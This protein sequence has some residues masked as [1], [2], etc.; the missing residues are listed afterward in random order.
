MN[1]QFPQGYMNTKKLAKRCP[2]CK[3]YVGKGT[4][5]KMKHHL[6]ICES[7]PANQ[8]NKESEEK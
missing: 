8:V 6:P 3:K 5:T 7:N 1:L 4:G 2:Y